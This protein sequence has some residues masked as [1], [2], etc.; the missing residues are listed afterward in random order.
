MVVW[1][2]T[3]KASWMPPV[4]CQKLYVAWVTA[5]FEVMFWPQKRQMPQDS[6]G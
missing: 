1:A 6:A 2:V 5:E 3:R 4:L